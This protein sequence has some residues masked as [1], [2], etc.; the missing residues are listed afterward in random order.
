MRHRDADNIITGKDGFL[1]ETISF[2]PK[3][4]GQ[5]GGFPESRIRD[6]D[7]I[8]R[9]CHG[10]G[11]DVLRAERP[12]DLSAGHPGH[13]P[14]NLEDASHTDAKASSGKRIAAALREQDRVDSQGRGVAEDRADIRRI[15]DILE[16]RETQ[17][18]LNI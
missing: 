11:A 18:G 2:V 14:W 6:A 13:T 12:G 9:E 8:V 17:G 7:G 4:N 10:G 1:R 3:K 15:A 5:A 16:H